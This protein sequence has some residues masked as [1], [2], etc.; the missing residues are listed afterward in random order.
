MSIQEGDQVRLVSADHTREKFG[1]SDGMLDVGRYA[2]V[3]NVSD[4]PQSKGKVIRVSG[5]GFNYSSQD[6]EIVKDNEERHLMDM[7]KKDLVERIIDLER[8]LG[9][10]D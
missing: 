3:T 10:L 1:Y 4:Y 8:K 6:F 7:S 2:T 5:N 9:I